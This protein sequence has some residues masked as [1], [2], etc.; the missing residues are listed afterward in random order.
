MRSTLPG[1]IV[2]IHRGACG[3][4]DVDGD[5]AGHLSISRLAEGVL[6]LFLGV[7]ESA[8]GLELWLCAD[9]GAP[10]FILADEQLVAEHAAPALH[11]EVI[12]YFCHDLAPLVVV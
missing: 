2:G 8:V 3:L 4:A 9:D 10:G 12:A 11:Y 1:H 6:V 5:G 7:A